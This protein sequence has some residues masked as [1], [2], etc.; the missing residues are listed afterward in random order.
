MAHFSVLDLIR[1]IPAT[2]NICLWN[3]ALGL[4]CFEAKKIKETASCSV[5]ARV[6]KKW[7]Y[8]WS[9]FVSRSLD[10]F[11]CHSHISA[12][13]GIIHQHSQKDKKKQKQKNPHTIKG[14]KS[15]KNSW[16]QVMARWFLLISNTSILG[17]SPLPWYSNLRDTWSSHK[18]ACGS[19]RCRIWETCL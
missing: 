9:L 5:Q 15:S 1:L 7:S 3:L 12:Q 18:R 14:P 10:T 16:V 19:H 2:P 11:L 4:I 17:Q 13:L 6:S 8:E